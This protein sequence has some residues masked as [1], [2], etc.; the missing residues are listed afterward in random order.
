VQV[1]DATAAEGG[2]GSGTTGTR[3]GSV[4][5]RNTTLMM[6]LHTATCT[7]H[8]VLPRVPGIDGCDWEDREDLTKVF[9]PFTSAVPILRDTG[10]DKGYQKGLISKTLFNSAHFCIT[11]V[12]YKSGKAGIYTGFI[13]FPKRPS[14]LGPQKPMKGNWL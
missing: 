6:D 11:R 10:V 8:S 12:Q 3:C 2:F 14:C 1:F 13:T 7:S 9:G 4:M 5:Q